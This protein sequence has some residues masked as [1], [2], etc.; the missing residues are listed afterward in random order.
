M[1]AVVAALGWICFALGC[2]G[3]AIAFAT[4]AL[5]RRRALPIGGAVRP[6]PAITLLKPLHGDEP[7][8]EANLRSFLAQDY[9]SP[10]QF[11]FGAHSDDDAALIVVRKLL[12]EH[13]GTDATIIADARSRGANPK[14]SNLL[15]IVG[16]ARHDI[17]VISDSDIGVPADY[18]TSIM[19]ALDRPGVGAVTAPYIGRGTNGLWSCLVAM[20][21]SYWFLPNVLFGTA[22]G[23]AKP[24]FGSTIALKRS[25]LDA[26][27]GFD[28]FK[29]HLADDYEI[30]RAVRGLGLAV[31]LAP[32]AV[33]HSCGEK[34]LDALWRH[35]L[36]WLR[37]IGLVDPLGHLGSL[38]TFPLAWALGAAILQGF[39]SLSVALLVAALMARSLIKWQ[40]DVAFGARSGPLWLMPVR[41]ILSFGL[42]IGS[43]FATAVDWQGAS[44]QVK[45]DGIITTHDRTGN[46]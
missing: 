3:V 38:V 7:A 17:L 1:Q 9:G 4:A 21:I 13:P 24:C 22:L 18:L 42:Y 33:R 41:D 6:A 5:S 37:T 11:V 30:G 31:V 43:L 20:G 29:D 27:G 39:G 40:I 15:N 28:A 19:A 34:T 10:V 16:A 23:V 44:Y 32:I 25:T 35:E 12:A 26:V 36:R 14:V 2:C 8:L 46:A 45:P